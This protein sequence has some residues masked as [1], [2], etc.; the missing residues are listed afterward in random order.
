MVRFW[1]WW[2]CEHRHTRC[3]HGD[4]IWQHFMRLTYRGKD[5]PRQLCLDCGRALNRSLPKVC[6][7]TGE[8]H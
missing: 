1:R 8:P 2:R 3:L 7:W 5:V 4:E 6:T